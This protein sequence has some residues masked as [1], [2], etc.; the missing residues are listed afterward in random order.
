MMK[1]MKRRKFLKA[2]V[3][4]ALGVTLGGARASFAV[5]ANG[6]MPTRRLG[7]TGYDAS[8][9]SLGGMF[10]IEERDN[11]DEAVAIINRALDLGV[12][13]IDSAEAYGDGG[14]ELNIGEVMR[15][16]RDEVFLTTKTRERKAEKIAAELFDNSLERLQTDHVDLYF[17]H[18]VHTS[19]VLD[20][21]LD[22]ETGAITA[23]EKFRD[24]GRIR[25]IGISSHS[26]ALL[27]EA[28]E[29]YD[30]DCVFVTL[31]P[32][33]LVMNG[34]DN[35]TDL[36][37]IAR[38]KDVGVVAMK[39]IGGGGARILEKGV[40]IEQAMRYALSFPVATANIGV[41]TMEQLEEDVRLAKAFTPL[42]AEERRQLEVQAGAHNA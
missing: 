41:S 5:A 18:G 13:Y 42:N 25:H 10:T 16:R 30:F 22:R 8:I 1:G 39:V 31:N 24:Q 32:A 21:T 3:S 4:T 12:N 35:V 23:I 17:C 6:S 34:P 20:E 27:I 19:E 28:L 14:S 11:R 40:A 37:E 26:T 7:K 36:F 38:E 33:R 9:F 29:R 15:S 2:A